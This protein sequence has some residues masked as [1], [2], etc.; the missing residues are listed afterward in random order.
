MASWYDI[1]QAE[2][3]SQRQRILRMTPAE[4]EAEVQY[5][6]RSSPRG[7]IVNTI[8][9][10]QALDAE[11]ATSVA[12]AASEPVVPRS[13]LDQRVWRDMVEEPEK[14]GEDIEDWLELDAKLRNAPGRWRVEAYWLQKEADLEAEEKEAQ[15]EWRA[16]YSLASREAAEAGMK[17]W[18]ARDIKR[19][20]A[21]FKN[22]IVRIQAAVRGHQVRTKLNFLDCCMCLAHTVCPLETDVG[23]MCRACAEQGPYEDITGCDD[24]WNWFR[25]DYVDRVMP[26]VEEPRPATGMGGCLFCRK[27]GYKGQNTENDPFFCGVECHTKYDRWVDSRYNP[28]MPEYPFCP[29]KEWVCN[30]CDSAPATQ[31]ISGVLYCDNCLDDQ[32]T[33]RECRS[34]FLKGTGPGM[35]FCDNE[36]RRY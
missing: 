8:V 35:G 3:V 28:R 13:N 24:P 21:R 5:M 9:R 33:C 19:H 12:A 36:C 1:M 7:E 23:M 22:A 16:I 15:A 29:L 31:R 10:L 27:D 18:L 34:L 25:A 20:V 26:M 32:E 4:W 30:M 2:E 14:Y 6:L 17:A 11:R